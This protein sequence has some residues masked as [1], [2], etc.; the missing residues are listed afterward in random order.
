MYCRFMYYVWYRDDINM[1]VIIAGGRHITDTAVVV[2]A[3]EDSGFDITEV[4]QGGATGVDKIAKDYATIK[5]LPCKEFK[6]EW[7]YYG[8]SAGCIRNSIMS[9]YADA[10][11]L[12]WDG[13]SRG[14]WNMRDT[15]EKAKKPI[16]E[17]I[18]K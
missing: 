7:D 9:K 3:I 2:K 16:F 12:V 17:V 18:V 15:M 5:N 11:I 4:V 13:Q 14:S 10:L 8:K 6:A 1:K